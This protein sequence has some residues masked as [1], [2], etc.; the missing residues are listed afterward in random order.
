M[1]AGALTGD[2]PANGRQTMAKSAISTRTPGILIHTGFPG[3]SG[4]PNACD[5]GLIP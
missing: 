5:L 4:Q 2:F 1:T 3:R